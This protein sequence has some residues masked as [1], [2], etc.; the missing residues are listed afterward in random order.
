MNKILKKILLTAKDI[1]LETATESIPGAAIAIGGVTKLFDK[2]DSNNASAISEIEDGIITAIQNLAPS[3]V[4]NATLV[5]E[6][7]KGLKE[8]FDKIKRGLRK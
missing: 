7:L 4:S 8:D 3:E 1:A 2:D 6:G 5:A